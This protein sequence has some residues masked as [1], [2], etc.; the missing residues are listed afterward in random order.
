MRSLWDLPSI[1]AVGH[2]SSVSDTD[3]YNS[4]VT[5][6]NLSETVFNRFRCNRDYVQIL[7]HVSF[8]LGLKYLNLLR[9]LDAL[10]DEKTLSHLRLF[11]EV[12]HPMT[13]PFPGLLGQFSPT[14]FRY[15]KVSA[16]LKAMF[17]P[18][19]NLRVSEIGIG[20]GG[21]AFVNAQVLGVKEIVLFDLPEVLK[22]GNR[23]LGEVLSG[24][25]FE[26]VDGRNPIPRDSDLVISNYAFSE[27]AR[28]IQEDYMSKVLSRSS[29]GYITW[30]QLSQKSL[31]GM[32]EEEF[33]ER[34][35]GAKKFDEVPL[36]HSGNSIIAW[37]MD[38]FSTP[39]GSG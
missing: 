18:L 23:F 34:L 19:E 13:Y 32:S 29:R 26:K 12:G 14:L 7:E 21:Q 4:I 30:N 11:N 16:D 33:M 15:L 6:A 35:P 22:L 38:P 36:T 5:S 1:D 17:G 3:R 39:L 31:D 10:V 2:S 27:L 20:F 24:I 25:Q 37:G 9:D 28:G 8:E